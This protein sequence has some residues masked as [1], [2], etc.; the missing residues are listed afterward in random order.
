MFSE[1]AIAVGHNLKSEGK[2]IYHIDL[3]DVNTEDDLISAILRFFS[4]QSLGPLQPL[5][6]L[7]KQFSLIKD[8]V[9]PFFTLDNADS[10]L[11]TKKSRD[12]FL[13]IIKQIIMSCAS[14]KI[15]VATRESSECRKLKPLGQKLVRIGS[16]DNVFSQKLVQNCFPEGCDRDWR[17]VALFCGHMPFAIRLFCNNMP[18]N[19]LPLSQAIDNFISLIESDLSELDDQDEL[20]EEKLNAKTQSHTT[21]ECFHMFPS[22]VSQM[23][24]SMIWKP[25]WLVWS[26]P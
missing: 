14:V 23:L 8:S 22:E 24:F 18:P 9:S 12:R 26:F 19:E 15:L 7:L 16:V 2:A 11:Q 13:K 4:D 6:F 3:T 1:V 21:T 17:K 25:V 10:L 20:E 5:D